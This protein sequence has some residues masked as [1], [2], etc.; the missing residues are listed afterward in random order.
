MAIARSFKLLA[1]AVC[2]GLACQQAAGVSLRGKNEGRPE[3]S[4]YDQALRAK[5]KEAGKDSTD[6]DCVALRESRKSNG[7]GKGNEGKGNEGEGRPELSEEDKALRAK[8]KEAGKDSTDADCVALRESRKGSGKGK[9]NGN[10]KGGERGSQG[11]ADG[12]D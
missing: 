8:C 9:G 12:G 4:E 10:S 7:K 2:L 5:C 11:Q 1:L 6:A 3:L